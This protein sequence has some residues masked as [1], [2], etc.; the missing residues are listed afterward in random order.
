MLQVL[1][2]CLEVWLC[3]RCVMG[4]GEASSDNASPSRALRLLKI[5]VFPFNSLFLVS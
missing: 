5:A 4:L 3:Q 1:G 2:G